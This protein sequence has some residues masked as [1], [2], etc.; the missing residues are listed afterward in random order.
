MVQSSPIKPTLHRILR[1]RHPS[2]GCPPNAIIVGYHAG[3]HQALQPPLVLCRRSE[4]QLSGCLVLEVRLV[5]FAKEVEAPPI[6]SRDEVEQL[7]GL[8]S[9]PLSVSCGPSGCSSADSMRPAWRFLAGW[10]PILAVL[11]TPIVPRAV[12]YEL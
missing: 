2:L 11:G 9:R 1:A 8:F 12:F 5:P 3:L 4:T 7:R 6:V 10:P